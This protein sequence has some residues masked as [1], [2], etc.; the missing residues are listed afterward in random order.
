[1]AQKVTCPVCKSQLLE[2]TKN[3]L[4]TKKHIKALKTAGINSS[5]DPA[6]DLIPK[7]Q[8]T[9]NNDELINRL[10]DRISDLEDIVYQLLVRQE[11]ILDYYELYEN[12][13]LNNGIRKIKI[14]EVLSAINELALNN[15]RKDPW[16]KINDV[17]NLLDLK[18]EEDIIDFNKLLTDMFEKELIDLAKAGG[19]KHPIMY[20]NRT[21]GKVAI[22]EKISKPKRSSKPIEQLQFK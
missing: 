19:P 17:V 18:L 15:K 16:V 4:S 22:H 7:P 3:H 11:K 21:Y 13:P 8:N 2:M 12:N 1:M 20:H 14:E 10:E 6:L 9:V 5:E